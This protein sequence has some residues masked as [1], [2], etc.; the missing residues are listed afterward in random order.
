MAENTWVIFGYVTPIKVDLW[1][2]TENTVL[3]HL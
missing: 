3:K 1:D 2:P